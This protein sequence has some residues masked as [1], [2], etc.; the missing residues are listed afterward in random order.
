M[1]EERGCS[2][3]NVCYPESLTVAFLSADGLRQVRPHLV[4]KTTKGMMYHLK[5]HCSKICQKIWLAYQL[6]VASTGL[7]FTPRGAMVKLHVSLKL[8]VSRCTGVIYHNSSVRYFY[9]YTPLADYRYPT[10]FTPATTKLK[11]I[12]WHCLRL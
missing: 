5:N 9:F 6:P 11:S 2:W 10:L 7:V 3:T 8:H 4:S 1:K 12:M